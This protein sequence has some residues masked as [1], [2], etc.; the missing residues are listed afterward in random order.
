MSELV[1]R[2]GFKLFR[3]LKSAREHGSSL[4]TVDDSVYLNSEFSSSVVGG[5]KHEEHR[6][7]SWGSRL[8]SFC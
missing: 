8:S 1:Y 2:K 4:G 6:P 5:T 3:V 7:G